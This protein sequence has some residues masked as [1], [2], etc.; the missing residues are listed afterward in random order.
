[1]FFVETVV[2]LF[3]QTDLPEIKEEENW[4]KENVVLRLKIELRLPVVNF[5]GSVLG[6]LEENKGFNSLCYCFFTELQK[7]IVVALT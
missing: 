1:M 3:F 2:T 7:T 6:V 4:D 5:V